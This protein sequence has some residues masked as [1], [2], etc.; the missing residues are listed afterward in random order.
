MSS[1]MQSIWGKTQSLSCVC[2]FGTPWTV[3]CQAS[4]SMEIF[5]A[6]TLEWVFMPF[7]R[8]LPNPGI[9]PRSPS[10]QADSLPSEPP[11]EPKNTGMGSLSLLQG[12]FP[13]QEQNL[14]LVHCR[15]ILY[16]LNYQASNVCVSCSVM[17]DSLQPHG[18]QL[19][20]LL[21]PQ[22]S[23][24]KNTLVGCHCLLQPGKQF[25]AYIMLFLVAIMWSVQSCQTVL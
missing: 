10:L 1:I 22:V 8:D 24:G 18:Q 2:L 7:S 12:F 20:R 9:E 5:Q 25:T 19:T 11:G 6:R 17:S 3:H 13:T 15:Q 23:P 4:L 16:Q 14:G 21:C